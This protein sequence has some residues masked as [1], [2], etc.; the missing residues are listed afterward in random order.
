MTPFKM[1]VEALVE[2]VTRNNLAG[3]TVLYY[4]HDCPGHTLYQ[5]NLLGQP[6]TLEQVL[7]RHAH[8]NHV[9]IVSD[10]GAARAHYDEERVHNTRR[11][12]E[13]LRR[14]T[15]LYAWINPVPFS[16]WRFTT[17]ED[18][19]ALVPMFPLDREGLDDA[20]Q[21]LRGHP[22]PPGVSLHG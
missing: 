18:I 5:D 1:L 7:T 21:I 4:F 19:E 13:T 10:A 17:A 8:N 6:I 20:I 11:F 22:F 16:R 12:L 9:L 2:S 14:Y 15:Y 3:K